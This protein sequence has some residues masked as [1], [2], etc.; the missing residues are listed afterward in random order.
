M[1]S[2]ILEC[3]DLRKR[4]GELVAVDGVSFHVGPGETY[5]LLGPNGAG[6]TTTISIVCGLLENDGGEVL[7]AGRRVTPRTVEV[8]AGIG[9][10]RRTSRSTRT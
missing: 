1:V 3:R 9:Y 6:K 4:Y 7:V 5:G 8:R 2:W 10:Y